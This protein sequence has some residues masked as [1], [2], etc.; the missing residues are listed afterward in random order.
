M[1]LVFAIFKYYPFGGLERNF[2]RIVEECLVRGHSITI[3]TM[4][5][6]GEVPSVLRTSKCVIEEVPFSGF[7]NHARCAAY[8]SNLQEMLKEQTFDLLVGFNRMPGL[9]LYYCADVC[10]IDDIRRRRSSLHSLTPR[11]KVYARFEKAVFSRESKTAILALSDIQR[12]IYIK[13]YGTQSERFLPIPAG[14]DKERVR[15]GSS[16]ENRKEKRSALGLR[17]DD[18]MLLMVGSDFQR[19]GVDRSIKALAAESRGETKLFIAGKG[20]SLGFKKLA[21]SLSVGSEVTFLGAVDD[22]PKLLAAADLLL[23]PAYAENTGN[24]IVEALIAGVPVLTLSNCGYA[25]HVEES[26]A[27]AVLDGWDFSQDDFNAK[28]AELLSATPEK[29]MKWRKSALKYSDSTDFYSRPK[30]VA[31]IIEELARKKNQPEFVK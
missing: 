17:D 25:F 2:T 12:E 9:D 6:D 10:Y 19:K 23:H 15:T 18:V 16:D 30:V 26:G 20:K 4:R 24:A 14:I 29:K 8:V 28:L 21:K 5:W 11:H 13:E 31:D 1:R 27:G 3:F 22:V 7:S